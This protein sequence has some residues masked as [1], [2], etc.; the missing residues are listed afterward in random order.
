MARHW[1]DQGRELFLGLLARGD[2]GRVRRRT[3]PGGILPGV[4]KLFDDVALP[5]LRYAL[6]RAN[7]QREVLDA[8]NWHI[9]IFSWK[10]CAVLSDNW[11]PSHARL[12][13]N[14]KIPKFHPHYATITV[15]LDLGFRK[16]RA[17]KSRDYLNVVL[18]FVDITA[19]EVHTPRHSSS[20]RAK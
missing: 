14:S 3:F 6:W 11:H 5:V 7:T 16:S 4:G 1:A 20:A 10:V 9:W 13:K 19:H 15:I 17:G 8:I 12:E 18:F 2:W